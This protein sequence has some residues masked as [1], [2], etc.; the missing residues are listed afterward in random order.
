ME[1]LIYITAPDQ[2]TALALAQGL[3]EASL[4]RGAN[5]S[6]PIH[7]VYHWQGE[8]R[9]KEE[10]QLFLQADEGKFDLLTEYVK[11]RHPYKTPCIIGMEIKRGHKDFLEWIRM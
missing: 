5:I 2:A 4:A 3:V 6:G 11:A 8:I 1:L 9:E 7:S 10:W